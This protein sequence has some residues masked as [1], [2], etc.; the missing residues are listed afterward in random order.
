MQQQNSQ[1]GTA[2]CDVSSHISWWVSWRLWSTDDTP[3]ASQTV[4]LLTQHHAPS[5]NEPDSKLNH[6]LWNGFDAEQRQAATLNKTQF[7]HWFCWIFHGFH[8]CLLQFYHLLSGLKHSRLSFQSDNFTFVPWNVCYCSRGKKLFKLAVW[9]PA[10]SP[11]T[12]FCP[13]IL[14]SDEKIP[15]NPHWSLQVGA[16]AQRT[17]SNTVKQHRYWQAESQT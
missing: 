11:P 12:D 2:A 9:A 13:G 5:A 4:W 6:G 1:Y 15:G 8:C 17:R 3:D 10:S 7:E 14:W 16:G